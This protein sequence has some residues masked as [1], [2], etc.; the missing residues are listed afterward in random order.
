VNT[1]DQTLDLLHTA[2]T[3]HSRTGDPF[4]FLNRIG[5]IGDGIDDIHLGHI[6]TDTE[7]PVQILF[8]NRW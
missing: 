8:Q 3:A 1:L 5:A 6:H 7:I 2:L 4:N